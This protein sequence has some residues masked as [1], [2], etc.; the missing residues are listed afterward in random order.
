MEDIHDLT[1]K[2]E[3]PLLDLVVYMAGSKKMAVKIILTIGM[4]SKMIIPMTLIDTHL[5]I[6]ARAGMTLVNLVMTLHQIGLTDLEVLPLC[7]LHHQVKI[8]AVNVTVNCK[9]KVVIIVTGLMTKIVAN[10]DDK[11]MMVLLNHKT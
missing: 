4:T 7:H 1:C 3:T 10:N 9:V 2:V 6:I 11:M 5:E 8:E